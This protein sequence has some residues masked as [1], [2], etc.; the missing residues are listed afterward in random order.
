MRQIDGAGTIVLRGGY[1]IFYTRY[2]IQYL[3]QTVG[4]NPPF[5]GLFNYSQAITNGVPALTLEAPYTS[6][7]ASA[8]ISPAG[9][10]R[11]FLLPSNQQWNL[12]LERAMGWKTAVSLGYVGNK[13][14]HLF[15]S[16]NANA[17]Y[18]DRNGVVQR[19]F[20]TTYGTSA[21]NV[22][23][24]NGNSIYNAMALEVR[25]R[26]GRG[27]MFQGNW[28]WAKGIDDV[29][30]NVQSALLDVENLGR[31]RAD[32]DYVRRHVIK[33]NAAWDVPFAPRGMRGR[34]FGGWRLSGI[35]QYMTGMY[36]TPQ[37]TTT[38]GLSNNRP[39]VVAGVQANLP[40]DQR[41]PA[42][43]FNPAAFREVPAVDPVTGL[44]RFGNA[45]R[46]ILVGPGL[47]LV[48]ASLAKSFPVWKESQRLTFRLELFN[49]FNHPNYD[50]PD[51]NISNTNTVATINRV[52]KPARQAQFALR[53]DF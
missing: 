22:R 43:W 21:I 31:D 46:N 53:F 13:G 35:W 15:R 29:G 33:M 52:A 23:Q 12:T 51:S 4:V 16:I 38:G 17:S 44:P 34:F 49:A 9:I 5:A 26:A 19:R 36:F 40:R 20:S 8:S 41:T 28:T 11:N 37:F 48:D 45:G 24:S 50:Y 47:N 6:A 27:L 1:G 18:L 3:L 39:D 32:S 42:R 30:V 14:T 10:E 7:G 2:P 25:R